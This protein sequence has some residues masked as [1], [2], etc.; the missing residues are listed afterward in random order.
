MTWSVER[1]DTQSETTSKNNGR[2][3]NAGERTEVTA[4]SDDANIDAF[5]FSLNDGSKVGVLRINSFEVSSNSTI[6][7]FANS[8]YEAVKRLRVT[9]KC[10]KLMV[11]IRSCDGLNNDLAIW[12]FHFLFP[13]GFPLYPQQDFRKT[14][15]GASQAEWID[16][17]TNITITRYGRDF[18]IR[19]WYDRFVEKGVYSES[20]K[21]N[22]T[23]SW[24]QPFAQV[25]NKSNPYEKLV[26]NFELKG[27]T[28]YT[29]ENFYII[30]DGICTGACGIFAHL[31]SENKFGWVI[32]T[33]YNSILETD[34]DKALNFSI[35]G[36]TAT[37]LTRYHLYNDLKLSLPGFENLDFSISHINVYN[38]KRIGRNIYNSMEFSFL[39]P[40][41]IVSKFNNTEIDTDNSYN[42]AVNILESQGLKQC[43]DWMVRTDTEICGA[44]SQ[45]EF[46]GHPCVDG[47]YLQAAE[48]CTFSEC[49]KGYYRDTSFFAHCF[50][51]EPWIYGNRSEMYRPDNPDETSNEKTLDAAT[52]ILGILILVFGIIYIFVMVIV[53]VVMRHKNA[54][55]EKDESV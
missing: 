40:D 10:A 3:S 23:S 49:E 15:I 19:M 20:R 4:Q 26:E 30:T 35:S 34:E 44:A 17:N 48:N 9:E 51:V 14:D 25:T 29:P 22:I 37:P 39:E 46:K 55:E 43:L 53:G 11:D 32:G 27:E 24:S 2:K 12:T 13:S 1:P 38:Y 5:F 45:N 7:N 41:V 50:P 6:D 33:G 31:V 42:L 21:E 36:S 18:P 8:V 28:L 47:T 54:E 16:N 52:M